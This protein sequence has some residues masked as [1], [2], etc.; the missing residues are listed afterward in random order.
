MGQT[1]LK[2]VMFALPMIFAIGFLAPVVAEGMA[3]LDVPAPFGMER[4]PFALSLAGLWGLIAT[5][6]GRWL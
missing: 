1:A 2:G 6:T 3:A 4:L 5:I